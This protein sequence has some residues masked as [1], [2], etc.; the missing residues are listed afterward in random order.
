M[1]WGAS[2]SPELTHRGHFHTWAPCATPRTDSKFRSL[3]VARAEATLL[4]PLSSEKRWEGKTH[5]WGTECFRGPTLVSASPL[6]RIYNNLLLR[7]SVSEL[8]LWPMKPCVTWGTF[9][10]TLTPGQW[11]GA[12][13]AML[14][15]FSF[16]F[17]NLSCM[18]GSHEHKIKLNF[19]LVNLPHVHFVIQPAKSSRGWKEEFFP[20]P[21]YLTHLERSLAYG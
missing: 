18:W 2:L 1:T 10:H 7:L 19:S 9:T 12:R 14:F 21:Q 15:S 8:W 13:R 5:F 6:S 17:L 16:L 20:F 3:D 11:G 4:F